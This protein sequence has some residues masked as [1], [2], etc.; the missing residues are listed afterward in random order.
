M[1]LETVLTPHRPA[2]AH[3]DLHS[4]KGARS[5]EH[6]GRAG[7]PVVKVRDLAWLLF[8]KPDLDRAETFARDFGFTV[9]ARTD[10]ELRLRGSF[11]GTDA[12]VIRRGPH[13]RF[14]GPVFQAAEAAGPR[15]LGPTDRL[16]G[17]RPRAWPRRAHRRPGRPDGHPGPGG[18]RRHCARCAA[19]TAPACPELRDD[20]DAGQHY[21]ATG[22]R[23][24]PGAAP[25]PRRP[26]DPRFGAALDWYLETSA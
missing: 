16:S 18:A 8:E 4:E 5:H 22:P 20:G 24:P 1:S 14:V 10:E 23:A 6:R 25:R 13:S 26:G 21:P 19:R 12:V 17:A 11:A 15:P 7:N 9:T 2:N 3:G